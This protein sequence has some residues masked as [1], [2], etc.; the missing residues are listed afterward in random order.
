MGDVNL[1]DPQQLY[2]HW[3]D[4]QWN[5]FEVDLSAHLLLDEGI[6]LRQSCGNSIVVEGVEPADIWRAMDR[7]VPDWEDRDIFFPPVFI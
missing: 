2:R 1:F 5:P 4:G 7:A 6:R 3:E